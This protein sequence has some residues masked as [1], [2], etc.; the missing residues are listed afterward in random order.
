MNLK[1]F[2]YFALKV[3]F[4][5]Y[6]WQFGCLSK[7]VDMSAHSRIFLI[8]KSILLVGVFLFIFF[9]TIPVMSSDRFVGNADGT[10]TDTKNDLMWAAKDNGIPISWI[11]ALSYCQNF[12]GGGHTDWRMPTL[13][14][15]ENLYDPGAKNK[16]GYHVIKLIETSAQSLWA[17]ET[18]GFEAARFNFTFGKVY[19]LRKTYSGPTR[20]L[21][22][23]TG[24]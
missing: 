6:I 14:E 3:Y 11:D 7:E 10:V 13:A 22:V 5:I 24:K 1:L 16:Q 4:P 12:S 8:H 21:P 9:F 2:G 17:S 23:R 19:W 15:L 18:R 20:V